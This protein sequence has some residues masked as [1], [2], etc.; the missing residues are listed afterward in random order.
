MKK[1]LIATLIAGTVLSAGLLSFTACGLSVP[2]GSA[3]ADSDA[4]KMAFDRTD[5]LTNCTMEISSTMDLSVDGTVRYLNK[6]Q[7][8]KYDEKRSKS[9]L[10][11]IN[12]ETD[13]A[14]I[15]GTE[16]REVKGTSLGDEVNTKT[17]DVS[18]AYYELKEK[19]GSSK[20]YWR[21]SYLKDES[22][23]IESVSSK[24][25]YWKASAVSYISDTSSSTIA[26]SFFYET[27]DAT[28]SSRLISLFDKFTYSG[29]VYTANLYRDVYIGGVAS[30]RIACKVSVSIKDD[31]VV[32]LGLNI[33]VSERAYEKG[34]Y[35]FK[36]TYKVESVCVISNINSTDVSKKANKD[37]IKAI[38]KAK[39]DEEDS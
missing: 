6:E 5:E 23:T 28:Y 16:S 4:W 7:T 8:H 10:I 27:K 20:T 30:E 3:V 36:Y 21:A 14:Y 37:I 33:D 32:G 29:G 34:N 25:Y 17:S 19:E 18:K 39:A 35:D 31:Y 1:K 26:D 15:E 22:K 2:K 13:K 9:G 12:E 11:L 24:E 38:D